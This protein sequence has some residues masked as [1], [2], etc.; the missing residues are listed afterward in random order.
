MY[1]SRDTASLRVLRVVR[2]KPANWCFGPAGPLRTA[3][4]DTS[5]PQYTSQVYLRAREDDLTPLQHVSTNHMTRNQPRAAFLMMLRTCHATWPVD[6]ESSARG[7]N[8]SRLTTEP[9][10]PPI[11][12]DRGARESAAG[13]FASARLGTEAANPDSLKICFFRFCSSLEPL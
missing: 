6:R 10:A 7:I 9:P 11:Q 1:D 13:G 3:T 4:Y 12:W 2:V 5:S 8:Y